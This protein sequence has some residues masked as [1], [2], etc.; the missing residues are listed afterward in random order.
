ME[1]MGVVLSTDDHAF[2]DDIV[3]FEVGMADHNPGLDLHP[4]F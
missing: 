4:Q 1:D 2:F 3:L